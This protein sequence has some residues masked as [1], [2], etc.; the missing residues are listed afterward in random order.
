MK[1]AVLTQEDEFSHIMPFWGYAMV[2]VLL[3]LCYRFYKEKFNDYPKFRKAL[4]PFI[5]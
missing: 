1:K 4:I 2:M 3:L 5:L